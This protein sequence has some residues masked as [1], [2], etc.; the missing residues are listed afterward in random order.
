MVVD[1]EYYDLLGVQP[2]ST[3]NEI[4]KGYYRMARTYH[5]DKCPND[6]KAEEMFKEVAAA[7]EI[8]SDVDR[9][10]KYDSLGKSGLSESERGG[11]MDPREMFSRMFGGGKFNDIIGSNLSL[12]EAGMRPGQSKPD[13]SAIAAKRK[14]RS[15]R[16]SMALLDVLKPYV[17]MT[18]QKEADNDMKT[19]AQAMATDLADSPGGAQLLMVVGYVYEQEARQYLKEFLGLDGFWQEMKE[20]A[21]TFS[22]T[23][24]ALK[25]AVRLQIQVEEAQRQGRTPEEQDQMA[26]R[27]M[28][29]ALTTMWKMGKLEVEVLVRSVCESVL[30]DEGIEKNVRTRRAN[31]V[32]IIGQVFKEKGQ[33]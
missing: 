25:H 28:N 6:P 27:I 16:L 22:I 26:A 3:P 1:T 23:V 15:V 5:P 8:L 7:Y 29:E 31:G 24:N 10:A 4:K 30:G 9:R 11:T 13:S 19:R 14:E 33:N 17:E 32:R 12:F 2:D 18:D 20:R 21:H